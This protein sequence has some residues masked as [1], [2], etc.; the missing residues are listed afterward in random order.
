[1]SNTRLF[2]HES[3]SINFSSKLD[4]SQSHYLYKVMRMDIGKNFSLF[5]K[6]G[7][8]EAKITHISNGFIAF[9]ITKKLRSNLD[10]KE[11][12]LAFAPNKL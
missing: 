10:K 9:I 11:N 5:N 1:M 3:L 12:W 2:F 8:W 6:S 4:K 7:E